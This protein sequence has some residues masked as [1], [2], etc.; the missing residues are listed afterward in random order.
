MNY[1]AASC[2]VSAS[3]HLRYET[4]FEE[5]TRQRLNPIVILMGLLTSEKNKKTKAPS[6]VSEGAPYH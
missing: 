5:L 6:P 4:S 2:E 1:P 3:H